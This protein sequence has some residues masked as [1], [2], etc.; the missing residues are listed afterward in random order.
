MRK[1]TIAAI[2]GFLA[3]LVAAGVATA[4]KPSS[5]LSLVVVGSSG[6]TAATTQPSYTGQITFDISTAETDHP[7]VNVRCYQQV[8]NENGTSTAF[9]YDAWEGFW[10]GY[11]KDPIF[12]LSSGYWAG[13]AA[14]CAARLVAFD[15][16]GREQ[17]LASTGFH[18]NA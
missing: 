7:Y 1:H 15:R 14:D 5:S 11:Y 17:T 13:G 16:Q 9:V 4:G 6:G 12:T 2:G 3:I 18:V 8:T 10:A